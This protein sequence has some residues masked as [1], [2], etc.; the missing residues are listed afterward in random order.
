MDGAAGAVAAGE[1]GGVGEGENGE[2][3]RTCLDFHSW[4]LHIP[5]SCCFLIFFLYM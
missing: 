3:L 5:L 1:G 2:A 4:T